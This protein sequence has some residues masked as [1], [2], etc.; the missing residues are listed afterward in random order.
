MKRGLIRPFIVEATPEA[1]G[2][3]EILVVKSRAGYEAHG[4]L[5]PMY[6]EAYS[7][8]LARR[9]GLTAVE[10]VAV[11]L[12]PGLEFGALDFREHS[13]T[14]YHRLITESHGW[15]L[16]TVHLRE[17]WKP[18]TAT[19]RP[20]KIG[21]ETINSAFCYDALVQN[22]DRKDDNPN[23][24]WRSE[25][26]AM[27]D[28]DRAWG[29]GYFAS[30]SRPWRAALHALNLRDSCLF[31]HLRPAAK[32]DD[33]LGKRLRNRLRAED[34]ARVSGECL[35]EV[36]AAFVGVDLDYRGPRDY[37]TKLAGEPDDFFGY[38]SALCLS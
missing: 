21:Q 8:L 4:G 18:W 10:P 26:L 19:T 3:S 30:E 5:E 33:V 14:D 28:F 35:D 37:V 1:G 22:D 2:E 23:L 6:L 29:V 25:E 38:R 36:A 12:P 9:L 31:P 13:G 20:K 17:D 7:L 34:P 16:A 15:N 11:E 32:E 27:L 24:L